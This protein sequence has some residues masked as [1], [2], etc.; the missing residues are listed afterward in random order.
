MTA[1]KRFATALLFGAIGFGFGLL[2]S[3][4]LQLAAR[5]LWTV[6]F[7][8]SGLAAGTGAGLGDTGGG[9]FRRGIIGAL[10]GL[11]MGGSWMAPALDGPWLRGRPWP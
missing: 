10:L 4:R 8:L 3:F 9:G 5:P 2:T 1:L 7:A 11:G 6:T